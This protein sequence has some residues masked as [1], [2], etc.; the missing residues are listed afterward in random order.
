MKVAVIPNSIYH[1]FYRIVSLFNSTVSV[2]LFI[3]FSFPVWNK[4]LCIIFLTIG[5][6]NLLLAILISLYS[7][8]ILSQTAYLNIHKEEKVIFNI[9]WCFIT[10]L[11]SKVLCIQNNLF[12]T[13]LSISNIWICKDSES[14][15][16]EKYVWKYICFKRQTYIIKLNYNL[17]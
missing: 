10:L 8:N 16:L 15:T 13:A 14:F 11:I 9:Q 17:Q 1:N 12:I 4:L 6:Y 3:Q 7:K 2:K 5:F